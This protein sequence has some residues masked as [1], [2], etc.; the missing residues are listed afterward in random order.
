[1]R[2]FHLSANV[3]QPLP[4]VHHTRRIW[5]ELSRDCEQ[6]HVIASA[7]RLAYS[8]TVEGNL[9]LH[10]LPSIG[11]RGWQFLLTSWLAILVAVI[12][13]PDRVIAQCPVNGGLTAVFLGK[14]MRLPVLLE[15]HGS[16]YFR[17]D[18][19]RFRSRAS[20]FFY[21]FLARLSFRL[22]TRIRSLSSD[23][24]AQLVATYGEGIRK[25][26]VEIGNRVDLRVFSPSKQSYTL[27]SRATVVSVGSFTH[28]KGYLPLIE[29]LLPRF[30]EVRLVLVG[31]GPLHDSYM[32][33]ALSLGVADR[34]ELKFARTHGEVAS[35]LA[36]SDLYA[37]SSLAEGV[38][39]AILEAMAMG[40]PVVATEV[41]FLGGV[42][43]N[44][45]DVLLVPPD[46]PTKL[47][48]AIGRL[49]KSEPLRRRL[50]AAA[51]ATIRDRFEWSMVF[52][53]YRSLIASLRRA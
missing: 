11:G 50:G 47:A 16:H 52:D 1:M 20:H 49:L 19:A 40:L 48:D 7:G 39:R 38:P 9:H 33:R 27:G 21:R 30:P 44:E 23:M 6:Y 35:T 29:E 14:L 51:A 5:D 17:P 36:A 12:H 28:R 15:V 2:V 53:R 45:L 31:R 10:L 43:E 46:E 24:T 22:A 34:L 8:H 26:V 42:V 41:G 32:E 13:R 4:A 3:Y 37:H 25:K 18:E